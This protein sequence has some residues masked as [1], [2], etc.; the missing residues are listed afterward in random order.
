ME[1]NVEITVNGV[2]YRAQVPAGLTLLRMLRDELHLTGT[3]EGCGIGECGAC[4][5]ILDGK[6]VNACMVLAVEANG[7]QVKTIEGEGRGDL[8][9]LQQAF[10]D[11][12]ALQCGF[13]TPGMIMAARDLLDRIPKPTEDDIVEA[14]AG[15]VCRCTGYV[16]AIAAV[17]DVVNRRQ[18]GGAR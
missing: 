16:T 10:I 1:Y 12:H 18:S 15:Q 4:A 2:Q 9:D 8:S 13:C 14:M 17:Q 6:L 7:A 3:K 5:V 11:H